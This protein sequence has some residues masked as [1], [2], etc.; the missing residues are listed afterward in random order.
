MS[1][2]NTVGRIVIVLILLFP[3]V[4][5][6]LCGAFGLIGGIS[7]FDSSFI[8]MGVIC[9]G[10]SLFIGFFIVVIIRGDKKNPTSSSQTEQ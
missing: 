2:L 5:F 10:I 3:M 7:K 6:G 8:L 4:G 9:V 1:L